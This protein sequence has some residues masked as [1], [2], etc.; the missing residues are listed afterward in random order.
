MQSRIR[1]ALLLAALTL[2]GRCALAGEM[3]ETAFSRLDA[4]GDG[5]IE[6]RDMAPMRERMFH[7]LD[8]NH[9]GLLTREE[10]TPSS[11]SVNIAPDAIPWPDSNGD[12]QI[13]QVE[14]MNQEP[15]LIVRADRNGDHRVSAEEF[16]ELIAKR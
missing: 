12:G 6:A 5:Y 7:R 2:A 8:R 14:F 9:D 10:V 1:Q 16:R 15:A 3:G 4:D 11:P 13:S